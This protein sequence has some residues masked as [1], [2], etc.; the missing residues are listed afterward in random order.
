VAITAL[1]LLVLGFG[2]AGYGPAAALHGLITPLTN[3]LHL[4]TISG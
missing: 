3:A 1:L 4:N 2:L